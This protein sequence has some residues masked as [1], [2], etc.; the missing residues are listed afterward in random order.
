MNAAKRIFSAFLILLMLNLYLPSLTNAAES[1]SPEQAAITKHTPEILSTPEEKIPTIE[2]KKSSW[3][4]VI[5]LALAGGLAAVAGGGGGGGG[6]TP[7][8]G[9]VTVGW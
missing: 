8:T 1:G 2:E 7:T 3:T 6:S 9:D 4:W 5:L